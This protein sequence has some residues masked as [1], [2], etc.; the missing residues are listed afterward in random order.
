MIMVSMKKNT[1]PLVIEVCFQMI[2]TVSAVKQQIGVKTMTCKESYLQL[3]SAEEIM[4]MANTDMAIAAL[5]NPDRIKIIRESADEAIK[6][7]FGEENN[8]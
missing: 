4:K 5:L 6:E 7:K 2:T 8:E 1:A 3:N